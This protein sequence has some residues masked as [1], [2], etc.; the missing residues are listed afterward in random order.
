MIQKYLQ[1]IDFDFDQNSEGS[2]WDTIFAVKALF[3]PDETNF[4]R[5]KHIEHR[6]NTMIS[7]ADQKDEAGHVFIRVVFV[8]DKA[9]ET[10]SGVRK[11]GSNVNTTV[12]EKYKY[13]AKGKL[14]IFEL[15]LKI[16]I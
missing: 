2:F 13:R 16:W 6:V 15:F 11:E 12:A 3:R 4:F 1:K 10:R 8:G 5:S 7:N 9:V 14:A